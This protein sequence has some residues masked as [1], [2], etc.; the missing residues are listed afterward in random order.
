LTEQPKSWRDVIKV[1]PAADLFPMMTSDELRALGEDIR[2]NGLGVPL[3][4]WEA[5]KNAPLVLLDGRNRLDAM[6]AVGLPVL[7]QEGGWLDCRIR[8]DRVRGGD[9]YKFVLCFNEYRRHLTPELR[10]EIIAKVLKAQPSK[11]NRTIA[12][13][14]KTDDKTVG[15]VRRELERRAEIPHVSTVDDAKGR[16]QRAHKPAPKKHHPALKSRTGAPVKT[17]KKPTAEQAVYKLQEQIAAAIATAI[18]VSPMQPI[19]DAI[20][21]IAEVY[22]ERNGDAKLFVQRVRRKIDAMERELD[23]TSGAGRAAAS[24]VPASASR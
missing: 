24:V 8:C 15:S 23:Q 22:A 7:D 18:A 11:S 6:E 9:P 10:R 19:I 20:F 3:I 2:K 14:T 17:I 21:D 16:K 4:L 1:H 13:Q 5:E 12:K